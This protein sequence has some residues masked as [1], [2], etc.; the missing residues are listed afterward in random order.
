MVSK[1][2]VRFEGKCNQATVGH[3]KYVEFAVRMCVVTQLCAQH[4]VDECIDRIVALKEVWERF[5]NF[6][7]GY[8]R[9]TVV[10]KMMWNY[11]QEMS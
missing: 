11:A 8:V 1:T 9:P 5:T 10:W 7:A 6:N 3:T 2:K 4:V